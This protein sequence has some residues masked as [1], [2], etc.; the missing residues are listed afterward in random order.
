[1]PNRQLSPYILKRILFFIL[2]CNFSILYAQSDSLAHKSYEDL[3]SLYLKYRYNNPK[4]AKIY[5]DKLYAKVQ[6]TKDDK[7]IGEALYRKAFIAQSLNDNDNAF[8]Y[9]ENS[10][11]IAKK[12][13][14]DSLILK[15]IAL[16][17][18][19]FSLKG[20]YENAF[21]KYLSAKNIANSMGN[22][23]D[24]IS[25]NHKMGYL[26]KQTKDLKEAIQI[27]IENL[28]LIRQQKSS[29]LERLEIKSLSLLTDTYQRMQDYKNAE[30]YV[31]QALQK[32]SINKFQD[33]YIYNS[34]NKFIISF[35]Q[36]KYNASI[37]HIN[38]LIH[39]IL[40]SGDRLSLTTSYLYL[41]KNYRELKECD[42][43]IKYYKKIE[44][45]TSEEDFI[46][47]EMEEVYQGLAICYSSLGNNEKSIE[48]Q[49]L[50]I[51]LD[52]KNDKINVDINNKIHEEHDV[53]PLRKKIASLDDY[54]QEQK[55]LATFWYST[56]AILVL[57]LLLFFFLYRKKQQQAKK[58]FQELLQTIDTLE[59]VKTEP[60]SLKTTASIITDESVL[61]ILEGLKTFEEKEYY[62]RQDCTLAFV[63]KKLKTNTSYLSN[64]INT[65]K[66][67][68]FKSYLTELRINAALIRLK[69]DP[70]LRA[71]TIK[72]IAEEF[73]FKRQ[74]T[75]SK[76][77]K[78]QTKILPSHYIK[79]V[80]NQ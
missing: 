40:E 1:M 22:I 50:S 12:I 45:I 34:S 62:L 43:V 74:E 64:V 24:I 15:N 60:Q 42:S 66:E 67:K 53:V 77:F 23:N 2:F 55:S 26:K 61:E 5:A 69:N 28:E 46:F 30:L 37:N 57:S 21:D 80:K 32:N 3:D 33:L 78:A 75:F 72:A 48:Y 70:K 39:T 25:I 59:Q 47:P 4:K 9:V 13:N 14:S 27:F 38:S 56:S 6:V 8:K 20:D 36:G 54:G 35:L 17:G 29:D 79:S 58:R 19:I 16:K 49:E 68:S 76:A 7:K 73:G 31:N 52:E 10:L 63:A 41:G 51:K 18:D 44:K 65:Y 11:S 71:Y